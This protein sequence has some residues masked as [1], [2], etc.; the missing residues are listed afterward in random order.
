VLPLTNDNLVSFNKNLDRQANASGVAKDATKELGGTVSSQITK[1]VN[2]IGN[3]ARALDQV[4]GPTLGSLIGLI[5]IVIAKATEGIMVLGQMFSMNKNT[6]IL[7]TA[8]ESG[9]VGKSAPGRVLPGAVELLGEKRTRQLQQQSGGFGSFDSKK[10]TQL[11]AQQPEIKKLLG[12]DKPAETK[13]NATG[14]LTTAQQAALDKLL[15][16]GGSGRTRKK[17]KTDEEKAAEKA[18]KEAARLAEETKKQLADAFKLNDLAAANLDIQVS[19]NEA[20]RLKGE[21][22]KAAVERR[23]QFLE[24]QKNAKSQQE[25]ELLVSAQ[26]SEVLIANN[27][28]A[29]DKKALLDQ[30][31]KPLEDIITANKTKLEDDKAYQRLVAEGINPELAKQ[32][33]EIDRAGKA[34]QE[35]LQ[36]S[37][38]LAKAAVLEAEARGASAD[39]VA[40]LKKELE[41]LQ[42]LPGKKV[43]E[44]KG[45]VVPEKPKTFQETIKGK[46]DA[47]KKEL[48]EMASLAN[49]VSVG[50]TAIGD[51][52]A[53]SF[54][55]I[56]S[57]TMGAKEALSSFFKS[58]ADAFLQMATQIIAKWITLIILNSVLS[59]F[60]G[61][62]GGGGGGG[63]SGLNTT[64]FMKYSAFAEG[65]YVNG[66]TNAIIGEGGQPEYVIPASKMRESMKRYAAGARG[67]SVLE[68][69]SI[70]D[71]STSGGTTATMQPAAIDVRYTVERI[72]SVDYVTADQFQNGMAE[73]AKQGAIRG[74][75]ATL[76]R[77]Q[78][79]STTRRRL[80]M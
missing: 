79:S 53:A 23:M 3:L 44:A 6:T 38:D 28:Y 34:L 72:N 67:P 48:Q 40:R 4:L 35:S 45:T 21:F 15:Q 52:F 59:L 17:G 18:A 63:L 68:G 2:Q 78:Q 22:D 14:G 30:Q 69:G 8:I 33:I 27:K 62:K 1:M 80:G 74:E 13:P 25:R 42:K 29:K 51:A 77:L 46:A 37:I 19:M 47:L 9:D 60:G 65:G 10:F 76:R 12:T 26:L 49:V 20:E 70:G 39:E 41:D 32:F 7:K 66:P 55:G 43:E 56:I 73:A 58:V 36:P 11:L 71:T 5:N 16:G 57:G 31:L 50:A 24:L 54:Q 75:Q 64:D 61:A